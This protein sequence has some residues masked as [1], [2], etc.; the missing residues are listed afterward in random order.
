[1]NSLLCMKIILRKA[2]AT[3]AKNHLELL[4]SIEKVGRINTPRFP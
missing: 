4:H 2:L 3:Y 1:M